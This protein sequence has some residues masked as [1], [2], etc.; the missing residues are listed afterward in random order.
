MYFQ[1]G[2]TCC[3]F[4]DLTNCRF[5]GCPTYNINAVF[6][7]TFSHMSTADMFNSM[8]FNPILVDVN[9]NWNVN[10]ICLTGIVKNV[11]QNIMAT[12]LQL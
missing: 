7:L 10:G 9:K 8:L 12:I 2:L 3:T 5:G 6:K 4:N 1:K 11:L